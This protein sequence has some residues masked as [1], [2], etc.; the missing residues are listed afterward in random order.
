LGII[1]RGIIG[2]QVELKPAEREQEAADKLKKVGNQLDISSRSK[3]ESRR[4]FSGG[5][6]G[7][8]NFLMGDMRRRGFVGDKRQF[9]VV[10]DLVHHGIVGEE[11]DDLHLSAALRTEEWVNLIDL[12]NHLSP[13]SAGNPWALEFTISHLYIT[14]CISNRCYYLRV[15]D[16]AFDGASTD[17][18]IKPFSGPLPTHGQHL[19]SSCG[20]PV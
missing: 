7:N 12:A 8:Q 17:K 13:A 18:T 1:N 9:D 14:I 6:S 11:R 20:R 4:I 2:C 16:G 10:N 15:E 3:R 19:Q 5:L